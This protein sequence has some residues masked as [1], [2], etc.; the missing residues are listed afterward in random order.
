MHGDEFCDN[1]FKKTLRKTW[2]FGISLIIISWMS[3]IWIQLFFKSFVHKISFGYFVCIW[4]NNYKNRIN[5]KRDKR[6]KN[7][8]E[9]MFQ[10][11]SVDQ[12]W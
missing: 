6:K 2:T 5:E 10:Y 8:C 1:V 9:N 11:Y 3:G 12:F 7:R 4:R